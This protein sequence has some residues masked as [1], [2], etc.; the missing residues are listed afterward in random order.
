MFTVLF[1]QPYDI[2]AQGFCFRNADEYK[3]RSSV[4]VNAH[5][6]PVGEFEIQFIDGEHIDSALAEAIS[7]NQSNC[8]AFFDL[9]DELDKH[10]KLTLIIAVGECGYDYQPGQTRAD[11]F[12]I[13][14]YAVNS[15]RELAEQFVDD[16]LLGDTPESLLH[17][18]NYDAF[19]RD[20]AIEY[21]EIEI[22]N[23][24]YMYRCS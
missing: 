17:Y 3:Q 20:L 2:S 11:D 21:S 18:F 16:G 6:Q 23:Q 22:A 9:C 15:M 24:R 1:A 4:A 19:A 8:L 14:I 7:L 12:D 10:E 5:G 13:E